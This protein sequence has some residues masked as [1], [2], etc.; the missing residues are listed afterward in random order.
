MEFLFVVI[1]MS[2]P[3]FSFAIILFNHN[4]KELLVTNKQKEN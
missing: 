1:L 2:L 3:P 4:D